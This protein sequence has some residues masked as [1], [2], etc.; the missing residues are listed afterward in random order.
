MKRLDDNLLAAYLE[1]SLDEEDTKAVEEIIESDPELLDF[2]AEWVAMNETMLS[3]P[4]DE[5]KSEATG[6]HV[7]KLL[8]LVRPAARPAA[9]AAS[10]Y[11]H[12][13]MPDSGYEAASPVASNS[14]PAWRKFLIAA[15]ILAF[16]CIPMVILIRNQQSILPS[17][18]G[19]NYGTSDGTRP[20]WMPD[21]TGNADT[22]Q[23]KEKAQQIDSTEITTKTF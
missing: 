20:A 2:V 7:E 1:G 15:S 12:I 5:E 6:E 17:G 13:P 16:V 8:P 3:L 23:L 18:G 14:R 4:W 21:T 11:D 22:I 9:K 19:P 10:G